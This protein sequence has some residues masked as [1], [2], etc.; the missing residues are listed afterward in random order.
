MSIRSG[1]RPAKRKGAKK[2]GSAGDNSGND[3]STPTK[4]KITKNARNA[5]GL[6]EKRGRRKHDKLQLSDQL[7]D[8]FVESIES[9]NTHYGDGSKAHKAY[10]KRIKDG[11]EADIQEMNDQEDVKKATQSFKKIAVVHDVLDAYL[12]FGCSKQLMDVLDKK[13]E[14]LQSHP[15]VDCKIPLPMFINAEHIDHKA[16]N[17]TTAEIFWGLLSDKGLEAKGIALDPKP[18]R[19]RLTKLRVAMLSRTDPE[20]GLE[21]ALVDLATKHE[22]IVNADGLPDDL[23]NLQI[24][25]RASRGVDLPAM[26]AID[27]A[28]EHAKDADNHPILHALALFPIGRAL[29]LRAKDAK[30]RINDSEKMINLVKMYLLRI[31]KGFTLDDIKHFLEQFDGKSDD[32]ISIIVSTLGL[33]LDRINLLFRNAA[34]GALMIVLGKIINDAVKMED[35]EKL[36]V[37]G[38][39]CD[40]GDLLAL[41]HGHGDGFKKALAMKSTDIKWFDWLD[42][43]VQMTTRIPHEFRLFR[44]GFDS[45]LETMTVKDASSACL[46]INSILTDDAIR[47]LTD[48]L[49]NNP[50]ADHIDT[51]MVKAM[52]R[53]PMYVMSQIVFVIISRLIGFDFPLHPFFSIWVKGF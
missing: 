6:G 4:S 47:L 14:Y 25:A 21:A 43:I 8:R 44:Q 46:L 42:V 40:V 41:I 33:E 26:C 38:C 1:V 18:E 15:K 34:K 37:E 13:I 10:L 51:K 16:I 32:V 27:V 50:L 5:V 12:K 17:A 36:E 30:T 39:G 31:L 19:M 45:G 22:G 7:V 2:A 3:F 29:L 35:V 28:C 20:G 48:A 11:L 52:F 53:Q 9:D 24:L 23:L 49:G